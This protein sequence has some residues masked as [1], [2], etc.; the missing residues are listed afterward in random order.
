M[1]KYCNFIVLVFVNKNQFQSVPNRMI[2]YLSYATLYNTTQDKA[3]N[4]CEGVT[5]VIGRVCGFN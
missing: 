1:R 5:A 3:N 4:N 2:L